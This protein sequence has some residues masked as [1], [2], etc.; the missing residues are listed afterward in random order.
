MD[1]ATWVSQCSVHLLFFSGGEGRR[2][3]G[4]YLVV[5]ILAS[6]LSM[7]SYL[8][9]KGFLFVCFLFVLISVMTVSK[10]VLPCLVHWLTWQHLFG[11]GHSLYSVPGCEHTVER[12]S[13]S[14]RC[15]RR[16]Q[17]RQ[18]CLSNCGGSATNVT[19][20]QQTFP[21]LYKTETEDED[22]KSVETND[23]LFLHTW[24]HNTVWDHWIVIWGTTKSRY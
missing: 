16:E 20:Q 24:P 5:R 23:D 12:Q 11:V 2:G 19:K 21:K 9:Y 17:F 14:E 4:S 1:P 3:A 7:S 15:P 8:I 22:T 6:K 13:G 10:P 18:H